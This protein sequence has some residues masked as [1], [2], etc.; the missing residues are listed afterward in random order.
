MFAV[1]IITKVSWV[2]FFILGGSLFPI[3]IIS[4]FLL[5]GKIQNIDLD[6]KEK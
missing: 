1:P 5:G 4:V 2:P 6:K 3:S